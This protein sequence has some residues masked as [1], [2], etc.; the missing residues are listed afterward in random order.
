MI[1]VSISM[2]DELI[3]DVCGLIKHNLGEQT[4]QLYQTFYQDKDQAFIMTSIN[5]LLI[6][7]V[8][9]QSAGRQLDPVKQ[10]YHIE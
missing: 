4:A 8:G 3:D 7:L 1:T 10:K 9:P 5:E 2:K 6:E